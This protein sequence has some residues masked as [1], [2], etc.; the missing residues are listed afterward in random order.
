MKIKT[1]FLK[2]FGIEARRRR[3]QR[4]QDEHIQ[5]KKDLEDKIRL[6]AYRRMVMGYPPMN[7]TAEQL[8]ILPR[9]KGKYIPDFPIETI[10]VY[11][12]PD[13]IP[14][15]IVIGHVVKRDDLLNSQWGG[16]AMSLPD[17]GINYYLANI[18]QPPKEVA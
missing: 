2:I 15:I 5:Y 1:F 16:R 13:H 18:V 10:F 12:L 3:I 11:P 7:L 17:K 9:L 4:E 14:G 6:E 8:A